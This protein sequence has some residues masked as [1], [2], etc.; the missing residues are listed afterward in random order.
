MVKGYHSSH[1]KDEDGKTEE[2]YD[3]ENDEGENFNA[4]GQSGSF[5]EKEQSS[6][7][8]AHEDAQ[9]KANEGKQQKKYE[10]EH[11]I[12]SNNGGGGQFGSK[13][14]GGGGSSFGYNNG[15]GEES[16]QGHNENSKFVKHHPSFGF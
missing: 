6:F 16:I 5:G 4:N 13:K 7:K 3:E 10:N 1:R 11:I 14:F 15:G 9:L 8:G 12:D 2:F